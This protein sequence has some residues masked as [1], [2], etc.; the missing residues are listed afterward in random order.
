[1]QNPAEIEAAQKFESPEECYSI[2]SKT[3]K[4]GIVLLVSLAGFFSPLSANIYFPA[5]EY[6]G[7][8]LHV[9]LELMN[10][11]ITA[12][13]ICQGFV[14]SIVGG[15]ADSLG[16]RP[17]YAAAL[18]VYLIANVGLALQDSYP[19][20]LVLRI[21]Q[22]S[23]SSGQRLRYNL[24]CHHNG[25][26]QDSRD[27]CL[28]HQ[29]RYR[30]SSASSTW[31]VRWS[32]AV[33]VRPSFAF[34]RCLCCRLLRVAIPRPNT[35]PSIGPVLGGI[36]AERTTWRWIFWFLAIFSGICL[37]SI[38]AFLPETA[39]KIVGNGSIQP[40]GINRSLLSYFR[41]RPN[42]SSANRQLQMTHNRLPNPLDCLQIIC[43]KDTALILLA[44][45]IFYMNYSCMQASLS[46]L[47]MDKYGLNALQVGLTYL[48]YGI[49]CGLA[50]YFAG[51]GLSLSSRR[52]RSLC[53]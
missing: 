41:Q 4:R 26:N 11:T 32:C 44:N 27:Y 10:L 51:E 46:T 31:C 29:C 21:L 6:I 5:L 1:M 23:G 3:S 28:S 25:S 47:I 24:A 42:D 9:S 45:A 15:F 39:R 20:L 35:A 38:L 49:G 36:F 37:L 43:H 33:R 18:L 7:S 14:P 2:F 8:D 12:Y 34:D 17:I 19:A 40:S 50:S 52:L 16:R 22:S 48:P 13:L 30:H 53:L